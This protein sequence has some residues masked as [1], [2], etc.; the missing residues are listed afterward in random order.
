MK[1]TIE[2]KLKSIREYCKIK[3]LI[4]NNTCENTLPLPIYRNNG[5]LLDDESKLTPYL[6]YNSK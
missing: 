3:Y 2:Y 4:E 6:V 1:P 5:L